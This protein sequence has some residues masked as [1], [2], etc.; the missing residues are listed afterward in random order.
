MAVVVRIPTWVPV[1][2]LV[3][4]QDFAVALRNQRDFG[5]TAI[6]VAII[7]ALSAG[8]AAIG[9]AVSQA[10]TLSTLDNI[11]KN[12]AAV[13]EHQQEMDL[14]LYTGL[15]MLNQH[16]DVMQEELDLLGA[17]AGMPCLLQSMSTCVTPFKAAE[18]SHLANDS[19]ALGKMINTTWNRNFT[20][21]L[22]KLRRD[23]LWLRETS[24]SGTTI[25]SPFATLGSWFGKSWNTVKEWVA[26]W[27]LFIMVLL[28]GSGLLC[29]LISII[30]RHRQT[31]LVVK[32][33]ML[34]MHKQYPMTNPQAGVWLSM[35]ER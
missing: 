31:Q 5:A 13:L 22:N 29:L 25:W 32:Q 15:R 19:K 21:L 11:T 34:A 3:R 20:L 8:A 28:F 12:T 27:A 10:S 17:L 24:P 35:L 33:A 14:R 6:V 26:I 4:E 7:V 1:R 2:V 9:M 18:C 30:H 16:V 23:I